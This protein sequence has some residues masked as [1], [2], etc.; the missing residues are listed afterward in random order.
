MVSVSR[1]YLINL[2]SRTDRLEHFRQLQ[3]DKGWPLQE[4][5]IFEAVRGDTVGVPHYFTQ[6]GG[7][8]GCLRSHVT[9]LER[10]LMDG[11]DSV[12]MMEDDA[13]WKADAWQRLDQFFAAVPQPYDMLMLG[14]Q[15]NRKATP[16]NDE[17][18][19][20]VSCGRTHAYLLKGTKAIKSLLNLWYTTNV[21]IDW[22]M[23]KWQNDWRVFAPTEFIFGQMGNNKSDISGRV[24]P[25]KYWSPPRLSTIVHLDCPKEV[26]QALRERGI[27]TGYWRC[28]ETDHD[29]GLIKIAKQRTKAGL[30][31]W[32][33]VLLW[34]A[35]AVEDCTVGVWHPSITAED[36]RRV[37]PSVLAV[38]ANDLEDA[39]GQLRAG[40]IRMKKDTLHSS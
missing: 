11:L 18:V 4:P 31:Q 36:M 35:N 9:C 39:L 8:W 38:K 10:V 14:G 27:H 21:H 26:V 17:C 20:V 32:L 15:H 33:E 37:H 6:G 22:A 12:L 5:I 2:K 28:K 40:C 1:I 29:N 24:D 19:K 30:R 13:T 23:S 25:P 7:A 16:V 34:E 3:K